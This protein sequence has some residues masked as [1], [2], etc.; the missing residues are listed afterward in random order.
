MKRAPS[1]PCQSQG[2]LPL[3]MHP[4]GCSPT[5]VGSRNM[6]MNKTHGSYL[7][8]VPS[9]GGKIDEWKGHCRAALPRQGTNGERH[10]LRKKK[11]SRKSKPSDTPTIALPPI[12][13]SK[14]P[15][16]EAG[17]FIF[18]LPSSFWGK[19]CVPDP[20]F[21]PTAGALHHKPYSPLRACTNRLGTFSS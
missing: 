2:A 1:L 15:N 3:L 7:P 16:K 10:S 8:G 17:V 4:T 14:W 9:I 18:P 20:F 11:N 21:L 6:K 13:Y 19:Y 12:S 5:G